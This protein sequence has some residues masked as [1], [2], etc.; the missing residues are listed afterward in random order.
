MYLHV[1]T[2]EYTYESVYNGTRSHIDHILVTSN[3]E[4]FTVKYDVVDHINNSSDYLPVIAEFPASN[5]Y[6]CTCKP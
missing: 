1:S 6:L 5:E 4:L 3:L 2:V